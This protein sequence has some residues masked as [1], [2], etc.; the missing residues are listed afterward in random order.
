MSTVPGHQGRFLFGFAGEEPVVPCRGR[1]HYY[2]GYPMEDVVLPTRV[3]AALGARRLVLT[4]AA[5]GIG[6]DLPRGPDAAD[7]PHRQLCALPADRAQRGRPLAP[8]SQI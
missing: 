4:N 2:E 5:G 7:G 6:P 3:M 8:G 1:V